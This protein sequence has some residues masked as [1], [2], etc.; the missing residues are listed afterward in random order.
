LRRGVT[1]HVVQ[2]PGGGVVRAVAISPIEAMPRGATVLASG[3]HTTARLSAVAFDRLVPLLASQAAPSARAGALL[4]T[5]IKVIDVMCPFAVGGTV[6]IAGEPRTGTFVVLEEIVRRLGRGRD[7][8]SFFTLVPEWEEFRK[9]GYSLAEGLKQDGYGEGTTGPVQTFFFLGES[10]ALTT[11]SLAALASVDTMIHLSRARIDEK[12]Y[13]G[14]D[15]LTSRSRV[16]E[17]DAVTG[18]HR[19]IAA[20]VRETIARLREGAGDGIV[21]ERARRLQNFFGQPFYVAE[22]YTKRPGTTVTLREALDVCRDILDGRFDD[23]PTEAFYFAG[24]LEE[25]RARA[26]R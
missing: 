18:E 13:P 4:E 16:L 6:A 26:G 14:V 8:V 20:R 15:V 1:L 2:R 21:L 3:R 25:I 24:G 11:E 5:G 9:P 23:W 19:A 7:P 10:G 22:E 12:I 17:T